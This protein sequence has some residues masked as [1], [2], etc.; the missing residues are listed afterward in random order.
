M[1]IAGSLFREDLF[2]YYKTWI[3]IIY[4]NLSNLGNLGMESLLLFIHPVI[5][6]WR[7]FWGA[8]AGTVG[9]FCQ[10]GE[11]RLWEETLFCHYKKSVIQE[12]FS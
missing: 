8:G 10:A 12:K 2:Y 6:E 7:G 3:I 9:T 11:G 5:H 4:I 1:L